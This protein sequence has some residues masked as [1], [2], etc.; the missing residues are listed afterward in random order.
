MII[1][2]NTCL[3]QG[4]GQ[5]N[6]DRS[7]T[8]IWSIVGVVCPAWSSG[9]DKAYSSQCFDGLFVYFLLGC[10]EMLSS[11]PSI[12]FCSSWGQVEE[13]NVLMR[14]SIVLQFAPF[15][16][17]AVLRLG[18]NGSVDSD[19]VFNFLLH[20]RKIE[21]M[22]KSSGAVHFVSRSQWTWRRRLQFCCGWSLHCVFWY[23][24]SLLR[25]QN[26]SVLV[27]FLGTLRLELAH[28]LFQRWVQMGFSSPEVSC[29]VCEL[30]RLWMQCR[31]DPRGLVRLSGLGSRW[32]HPRRSPSSARS[33]S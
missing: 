32:T 24:W 28:M 6:V 29:E 27:W 18:L 9:V 20:C 22:S 23:G 4:F 10:F 13:L 19:A 12:F 15:I 17:F 11:G 33:W 2:I 21:T 5:I 31:V 3:L 16:S 26:G 25:L 14:L 30:T 7:C 1:I 8:V